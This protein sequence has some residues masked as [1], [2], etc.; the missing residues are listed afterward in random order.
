MAWYMLAK[1]EVVSDVDLNIFATIGDRL[2]GD[3]IPVMELDLRTKVMQKAIDTLNVE[4]FVTKF[5]GLR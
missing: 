4:S 2:A 5:R 1:A 3:P